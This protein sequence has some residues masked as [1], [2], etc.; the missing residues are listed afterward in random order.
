MKVDSIE[1]LRRIALASGAE[2]EFDGRRFNSEQAR[3]APQK[4]KASPPAPTPAPAPQVEPEQ[5]PHPEAISRADLDDALAQRDL[6][7]SRQLGAVT[8]AFKLAILSVAQPRTDTRRPREW[9]FTTEY[10]NRD[11]ITTTR[12]TPIYDSEE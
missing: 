5:P 10:D 3:V 2:V 7:W 12:A 1:A 9:V 6:Q 8:E 11:R 4:P